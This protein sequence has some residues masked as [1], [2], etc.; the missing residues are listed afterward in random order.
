MV[1]TLKFPAVVEIDMI[2]NRVLVF[3]FF[4]DVFQKRQLPRALPSPI[5]INAD[6][7]RLARF[8]RELERLLIVGAK[9]LGKNHRGHQ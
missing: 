5:G 7:D 1:G 6:K 2:G 8:L 3:I 4:E 9:P